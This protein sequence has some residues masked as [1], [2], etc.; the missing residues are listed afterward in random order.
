MPSSSGSRSLERPDEGTPAPTSGSA[1]ALP[2]AADSGPRARLR[3]AI[4]WRPSAEQLAVLGL[5]LLVLAAHDVKYMLSHPF[6]S[7]EAWVALTTRFPLSDL[8]AT[9]SS[10]PIGWSALVRLVTVP[11]TQTARLLPLAFSGASVVVAYWF[12]RRLGW[13]WEKASIAAGVAASIGALLAPGML[14]RSDLKQ[15]TTEACSV[16]LTLALTSQLEREWS[17]RRLAVLSVSVWAG[18]LF[19]NAVAF[20]GVAVFVAVCIVQ[21]V[22]RDWRRLAEAAVAGAGTAALMLAVYEAFDARAVAPLKASTYWP[23]FYLPAAK[24]LHASVSFVLS[25]FRSV[26]AY[27]G[28][29]PA[30]LALPLVIAGLVTMVRLGR[31]ATAIAVVALWPE[32]L[33]LSALKQFPF[34]NPRTSTFLFA[35][36]VVVAAVGLIGMCLLLRRWLPGWIAAGLAV[37]AVA[38]FVVGAQPYVRSHVIANEDVRDQA[39]YVAV[40]AAPGDAIAV[41]L[42]SNWG[43]GY[44]WPIGHPSRRADNADMQLYEAYFPGQPRV[45]VALNREPAGIEAAL[46]QALSRV[47][48]SCGRIW[49]VRTHLSAAERTAWAVALRQHGQSS[50]PVGHHGLTVVQ[51][52]G[53]WCR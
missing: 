28:L 51:V 47:R 50:K 10:S 33:A 6:W 31:P 25:H 1:L 41:N 5:G 38:A 18:M 46:A 14:V 44:Y 35:V 53:A 19:S 20:V 30:W 8:P 22:R 21:L 4:R 40:H 26:H 39:R 9:T 16:L 49:L 27:F 29:G 42:S 7:D 52:A 36:T 3:A 45:I 15:Y 2:G 34:L 43:F 48:H 13:R 24:G 12:A 11:G 32:L 17:R 23:N 37:V